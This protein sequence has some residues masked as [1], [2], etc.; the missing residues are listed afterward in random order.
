MANV[1]DAAVEVDVS[2]G[3]AADLAAPEAHGDGEQVGAL[4]VG[5]ASSSMRS[6]AQCCRTPTKKPFI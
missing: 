4:A 1:R 2:L 6:V 3:E 5:C